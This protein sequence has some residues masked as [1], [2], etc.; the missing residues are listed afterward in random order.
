[1]AL[2][3]RLQK[4]L[5]KLINNK[6]TGYVKGRFSGQNIRLIK[7]TIEFCINNE[8]DGAVVFVDF[9]KAFDTLEIEF[10]D[11]CLCK[12]G[13]GEQFQKWVSTLYC[14]INSCVSMN[15]WLSESFNLNRGQGCALSALLFIMAVKMLSV[16]IKQNQE[17]QGI[18]IGNENDLEIKVVQLADDTTLLVKDENSVLKV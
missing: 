16:S 1:M 4:V 8:E 14:N 15:G 3:L 12:M 17:I 7:D 11:K 6:Q 9:R 2:S 5:E 10:T 13:F 18:N